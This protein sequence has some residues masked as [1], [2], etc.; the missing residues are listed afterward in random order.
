ML[1]VY[2]LDSSMD[3]MKIKIYL[4]YW[5]QDHRVE[6]KNMTWSIS[7]ECDL[8][9]IIRDMALRRCHDSLISW[10]MIDLDLEHVIKLRVLY[11][12]QDIEME[13]EKIHGWPIK[14]VKSD[15]KLVN[16][17]SIKNVP[18][19]YCG[20]VSLVNCASWTNPLYMCLCIFYMGWVSFHEHASKV[21]ILYSTWEDDIKWWSSSRLRG[22]IST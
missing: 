19:G 4:E 1:V 17:W 5:H 15:F 13:H 16:T 6:E 21:N 9:R 14:R 12:P 7:W 22:A 2:V 3:A 20:M 11:V 18:H 8:N 10:A